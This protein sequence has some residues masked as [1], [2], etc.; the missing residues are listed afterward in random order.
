VLRGSS[1]LK[2]MALGASCVFVGRPF[3]YAAAVAGYDGVLHGIRLIEKEIYTNMAMLGVKAM[4]EVNHD[5]L[6][7]SRVAQ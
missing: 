3:N 2:A 7:F 6:Y 4:N 5:C 1:V